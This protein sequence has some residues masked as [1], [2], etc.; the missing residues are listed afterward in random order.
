MRQHFSLARRKNVY[1]RC[2]R[3]V[4]KLYE[5]PRAETRLTVYRPAP[6]FTFLV[7]LVEELKCPKNDEDWW[8][9]M[10]YNL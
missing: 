2:R 10:K 4:G 6:V 1:R 8:A 7:F 5:L 9:L 3:R